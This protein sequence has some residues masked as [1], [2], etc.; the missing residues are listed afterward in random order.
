MLVFEA[1]ERGAKV[2]TP[3]LMFSLSMTCSYLLLLGCHL[4][5]Q[6]QASGYHLALKQVSVFLLHQVAQSRVTCKGISCSPG[7]SCL[8]GPPLQACES[9]TRQTW[10]SHFGG[11]PW[12]SG[13][14]Q[15]EK[16]R[17]EAA[18]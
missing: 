12:K 6:W 7:L 13:R 5:G 2:V 8:R 4:A 14:S 17:E 9:H 3:T 16:S 18:E 15:F 11:R 1:G 10:T